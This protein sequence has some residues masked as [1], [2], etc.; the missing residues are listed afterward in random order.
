MD[1]N[2]EMLDYEPQILLLEDETGVEKE[3]ELLDVLEYHD[4]EYIVLIETDEQAED[5]VILKIEYL[6][7]E[8]EAYVSIQ[9]EELLYAVF[10]E[11]KNKYKDEYSFE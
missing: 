10:E 8:T 9:D 11:F 6:D 1:E 2:K 3:F 7:D 4:D 5:V